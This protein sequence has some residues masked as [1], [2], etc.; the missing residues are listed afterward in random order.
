MKKYLFCSFFLLFSVQLLQAQVLS[1]TQLIYGRVNRIINSK[2][3]K[4]EIPAS[5]IKVLLL[6]IANS[7]T[8]FDKTICTKKVYP[9]QVKVFIS[10]S[11]GEYNF[12]A[13]KK[14][15]KYR[16]IFCDSRSNKVYFTELQIPTKGSNVLR[17]PDQ[18]IQ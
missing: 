9:S 16:L 14:G 13:M 5:D 6:E 4:Y 7:A 18:N 10:D 8:K 1:K 11:K 3:G 15:I 2:N 12:N 17:V